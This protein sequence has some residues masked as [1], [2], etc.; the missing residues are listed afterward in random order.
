MTAGMNSSRSSVS[1]AISAAFSAIPLATVRMVPSFGFMTALY[2]VSLALAQAAAN[3][4]TSISFSSRIDLVNP[5]S[6]WDRIT[7]E[8]PLAPRREPDDMAFAKS[9][10][11]GFSSAITSFAAAMIVRDILVP[12]SPSGTGNTFNSLINSFCAS[13]FCAPARNILASIST[14]IVFVATFNAPP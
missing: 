13:I 4:S 1:P 2:A 7:P 12:V 5:L 9:F 14:F 10:I 8:F 6:S 11:S 3:D